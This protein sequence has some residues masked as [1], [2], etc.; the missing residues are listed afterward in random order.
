MAG[1]ADKLVERKFVAYFRRWKTGGIS[2]AVQQQVVAETVA[3]HGG[4]LIAEFTEAEWDHRDR[5]ELRKAV[6]ECRKQQAWLVSP[7]WGTIYRS[8]AINDALIALRD[9]YVPAPLLHFDD[10]V[11]PDHWIPQTAPREKKARDAKTELQR[12]VHGLGNPKRAD[13]TLARQRGHNTQSENARQAFEAIR[14]L[15]EE[16]KAS[17][18]EK[19]QQLADF[20][21]ARGTMTTRGN[22]WSRQAAS[23]L[24]NRFRREAADQRQ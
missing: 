24:L 6:A 23:E 19:P 10:T 7:T 21:N 22:P 3:K 12:S 8:T 20:L 16:A 11:V 4:K 5:P 14:P 9:D 1:A 13:A 2:L 15:V 17:G 18:H